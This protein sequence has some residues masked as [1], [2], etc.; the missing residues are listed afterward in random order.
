[1]LVEST[2]AYQ[3]VL[4][5]KAAQLSLLIKASSQNG[6]EGREVGSEHSDL[7]KA[8]RRSLF[9]LAVYLASTLVIAT[10]A[11]AQVS[12][13]AVDLQCL[14]PNPS[15]AVAYQFTWCYTDWIRKL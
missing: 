12:V 6:Y 7:M 1:M 3:H 11:A 13:P 5:P 4:T 14:S 2:I 8:L 9:L 10:P 15:G